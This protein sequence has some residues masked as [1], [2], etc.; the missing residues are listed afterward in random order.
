MIAEKPSF[1]ALEK[2]VK[3]R[4]VVMI[5]LGQKL[6]GVHFVQPNLRTF[7]FKRLVFKGFEILIFEQLLWENPFLRFLFRLIKR[8]LSWKF[9]L[10]F[11][12]VNQHFTAL[13]SDSH[14]NLNPVFDLD[15]V[16]EVSVKGQDQ[17]F[18]YEIGQ[19]NWKFRD[20]LLLRLLGLGF[21]L[22]W[23]W[24]WQNM[25]VKNLQVVDCLLHVI[26]APTEA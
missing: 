23:A 8:C 11:F 9:V 15:Q 17:L 3:C 14:L 22:V 13:H 5:K 19:C 7:F 1:F 6:P 25:V 21:G 20:F 18:F 2:W 24:L 16:V 12:L 4:E 10:F 26:P